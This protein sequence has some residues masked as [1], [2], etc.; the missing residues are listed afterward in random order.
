LNAVFTVIASREGVWIAS[1]ADDDQ[2]NVF[3]CTW[4]ELKN[5]DCFHAVAARLGKAR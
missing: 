5:V 4:S 2:Q 3:A 1:V